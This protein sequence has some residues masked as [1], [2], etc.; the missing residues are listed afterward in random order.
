MKIPS[1]SL[2]VLILAHGCSLCS[3]SSLM[4]FLSFQAISQARFGLIL[5]FSYLMKDFHD[6]SNWTMLYYQTVFSGV[7]LIY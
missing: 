4:K 1:I 5:L 3:R 6:I 7:Q 2:P